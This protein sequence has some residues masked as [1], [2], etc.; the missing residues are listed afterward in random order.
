MFSV[1]FIHICLFSN[2]LFTMELDHAMD[3]IPNHRTL[4]ATLD[5]PMASRSA[6]QRYLQSY[7]A[8]RDYLG[9]HLGIVSR[10]TSSTNTLTCN[11]SNELIVKSRW[12]Q[13]LPIISVNC[14]LLT[15]IVIRMMFQFIQFDE[16]KLIDTVNFA[17]DFMSDAGQFQ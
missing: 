3:G 8:A 4:L 5:D 15:Q 13:Y 11:K 10:N 2:E 1:F 9:S 6:F 17:I 16:H 12:I 14:N 7:W